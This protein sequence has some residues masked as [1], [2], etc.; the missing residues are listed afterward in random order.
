MEQIYLKIK[1]IVIELS[2]RYKI[3]INAIMRKR[4][5]RGSLQRNLAIA[6]YDE[7]EP[8]PNEKKIQIKE[9]ENNEKEKEHNV[10]KQKIEEINQTLNTNYCLNIMGNAS[11]Q[12]IED[13]TFCKKN[14]AQKETIL[15]FDPFKNNEKN[16][17]FKNT[18]ISNNNSN[19]NSINN[20]SKLKQDQYNKSK[21]TNKD[22]RNSIL[23]KSLLKKNTILS[24]Q[25]R[26]KESMETPK[27]IKKHSFV[28]KFDYYSNTL[29]QINDTN[30]TISS[31]KR[32]NNSY[33]KKEKL[34]YNI[35]TNLKTSREKSFHLKSSYDNINKLSNNKYIK[36]LNLQSK[37]RQ[38]LIRQCININTLKKKSTFLMPPSN[39]SINCKSSK[40]TKR[41][42]S[43]KFN[44]ILSEKE[45]YKYDLSN[46]ENSNN[47][48]YNSNNNNMFCL[49]KSA[50]IKE[51]NNDDMN[52]NIKKT[53]KT[54]LRSTSKLI[55][56]NTKRKIFQKHRPLH[57]SPR[58]GKRNTKKK[59]E[60][61]NK[62]LNI[63]S[64]NIE[65][66]SKNINNP[67]EFYMNFFTN[68]IAK[69][70]RSINGEENSGSYSKKKI[71]DSGEF[72]EINTNRK[73][74]YNQLHLLDSFFSNKESNTKDSN[75]NLV[76]F[77]QKSG[78]N[79]KLE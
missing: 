55:E 56:I 29:K 61:I 23:T 40:N 66:S 16:M 72:N 46:S 2:N 70:S 9:K 25:T 59:P 79:S 74:S 24:D 77:K 14:T 51:T 17:L 35:F 20:N 1:K 60:K 63:I 38:I 57:V 64:K 69:E 21:T 10:Q 13:M 54:Q 73:S 33:N 48:S 5:F 44:N 75:K 71:D 19:N 78:F 15:S 47:N 45:C 12:M 22:Y 49:N 53:N 6:R 65:N 67:E 4:K 43:S 26:G 36:D 11:I 42:L 52:L 68:I 41:N 31:N 34:I 7:K 50:T 30:N 76:K 18:N 8:N 27:Y 32:L 58:K 39:L 37:I 28:S 3:N 62:Q